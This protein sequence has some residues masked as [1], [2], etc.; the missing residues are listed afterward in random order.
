MD[1]SIKKLDP[2]YI[3]G[4]TGEAVY[5]VPRSYGVTEFRT[6]QGVEV[7]Q[8]EDRHRGSLYGGRDEHK[9]FEV[10]R[11][12]PNMFVSEDALVIPFEDM[13]AAIL[14]RAEPAALA[15]ALWEASDEVREYFMDA[16]TY[17]YASD[18]VTDKDR[19][20]FIAKVNGEIIDAIGQRMLRKT[21]ELEDKVRSFN[22]H[23]DVWNE[24]QNW[25]TGLLERIRYRLGDEHM[26]A[27][28]RICGSIP[29]HGPDPEYEQFRIAGI[30][31]SESQHYWR[32]TINKLLCDEQWLDMDSAP[33][34]GSHVIIQTETGMI[35]VAFVFT[36][37]DKT[38][39]WWTNP[40]ALHV[41][42]K[43]VCWRPLPKPK[44]I[45]PAL[46]DDGIPF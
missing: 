39:S 6:P 42:Y 24:V 12:L 41:V 20:A 11:E 46:P 5:K 40:E 37:R 34:D 23:R 29:F 44:T 28:T 4:N 35:A 38:A 43:P 13:A 33:T 19:K 17:R 36:T 45:A 27:I 32:E 3:D 8:K 31:W 25:W 10:K 30:Y 18:A 22:H 21:T 1:M 15:K 16:L 9:V 26:Y 2:D 7:R 14:S